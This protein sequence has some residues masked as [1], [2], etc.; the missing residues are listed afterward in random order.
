VTDERPNRN[1]LSGADLDARIAVK[2]ELTERQAEWDSLTAHR[3]ALSEV[4]ALSTLSVDLEPSSEA[5]QGSPPGFLS[6]LDSGWNALR[7]AR[8]GRIAV[9]GFVLPLLVAAATAVVP[10][11]NLATGLKRR[12]H[13]PANPGAD[14]TRGVPERAP[15][16]LLSPSTSANLGIHHSVRVREIRHRCEP[17]KE[18]AKVPTMLTQS[19]RAT[20]RAFVDRLIPAD[21][22]PGGWDAGV[23]DYLDRQFAGD[24]S[25][26]LD[27][28]RAGLDSL[29][30]EARATA[31]IGFVELDP[32][33]Q[34]DLLGRVERGE[35]AADWS[36]DP[37]E[38]FCAAAEHAAEGYYGDP[39]NGGNRDGVSWRMIGFE[40]TG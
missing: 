31:G 21:D 19:Q 40:V 8:A 30:T 25:H 9:T 27:T 16:R 17:V 28:Y 4:V 3:E 23:G 36:V 35:V 24:L 10:I 38:F 6:E 29:D 2:G 32:A 26:V 39:A 22:Y 13:C 12:R 15:L 5:A 20:L 34:D 11:V 1:P 18:G 33:A 14:L 37:A 7:A